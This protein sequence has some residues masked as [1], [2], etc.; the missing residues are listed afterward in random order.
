MPEPS[1]DRPW[2]ELALDLPSGRLPGR[3]SP[4]GGGGRGP[5]APLARPPFPLARLSP[6]QERIALGLRVSPDPLGP[7]A[8]APAPAPQVT[9]LARARLPAAP[10]PTAT[11]PRQQE[12]PRTSPPAV[13][14]ALLPPAPR[15]DL[16]ETALTPVQLLDPRELTVRLGDEVWLEFNRLNWIL[17]DQAAGTAAGFL[18]RDFRENATGFTFKPTQAGVFQVPFERQDFNLGRTERQ[19]V[20]LRVLAPGET[21]STR[22]IT[23]VSTAE[24]LRQGEALERAG[25]DAEALTLYRSQAEPRDPEMT[26]RIGR[27]LNRLGESEAA[28][29]HFAANLVPENPAFGPSLE[30]A[31]RLAVRKPEAAWTERLL[32]LLSQWT[33]A[34]EESLF[35]EVLDRLQ[36]RAPQE[37]LGWSARHP[38]WYPQARRG[39]AYRYLTAQILEQPGPGRD[40]RR[41][42]ALYEG[43]V[44]D[45]PLSPFWDRARERVA[46][47]RRHF[48][49]F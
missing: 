1:P 8:P 15:P 16:S 37:G 17:P 40:I 5:E 31:T 41:A 28:W 36:S 45:F 18:R 9:D 29:E 4:E 2:A 48:L 47:I 39:D 34:P 26:L 42:L 24:L 21:A 33:R 30:E 38:A 27:I 43:L 20:T 13:P 23:S 3:L 25:K 14:P 46:Y 12:L 11:A 49:P 7:P 6:A 44:R 19:I 10:R 35:L 22:R 32:G